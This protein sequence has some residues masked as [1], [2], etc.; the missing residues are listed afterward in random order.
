M[1]IGRWQREP[2]RRQKNPKTKNVV[3][4]CRTEIKTGEN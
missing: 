1:R 2:K 4:N 3:K